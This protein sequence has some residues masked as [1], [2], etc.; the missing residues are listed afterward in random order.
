MKSWKSNTRSRDDSDLAAA[1]ELSGP[2]VHRRGLDGLVMMCREKV[3]VA[4]AN[5]VT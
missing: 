2:R 3:A 5:R 4:A 1:A